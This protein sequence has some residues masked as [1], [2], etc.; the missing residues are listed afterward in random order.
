MASRQHPV[1]EHG[2]GLPE[3]FHLLAH[4]LGADGQDLGQRGDVGAGLGQELVQRRVQQPD[5][6]GQLVH[7]AQDRLEVPLLHGQQ[8]V[9]GLAPSHLV[10][11]Q[12]HLP[13]RVDALFLKEH[14]LGAAQADALG[15]KVAADARLLRQVGV[16]L[17]AEPADR[18]HPAHQ[19]GEAPVGGRAGG[20]AIAVQQHPQHVGRVGDDLSADHFS[21]AA[22]QREPVPLL[23]RHAADAGLAGAVVDGQGVAAHHAHRA[24]LPRHQRRVGGHAAPGRENAFGRLD[25]ADVFRAGLHPAQDDLL[26]PGPPRCRVGGVEHD[27]A[28][29]RPRPRGQ[30]SRQHPAPGLRGFL[31]RLVEDR[32]QHLA[33]VVRLDALQRLFPGDGLGLGHIHGD[34]HRGKAGALAGPGLQQ[35]EPA[36]LDG[37]LEVLHVPV[38]LFQDAGDALELAI[39]VALD[40]G[41]RA[42]G[43]R[44]ADPGH[45]VLAL[46]VHEELAVEPPLARRRIAG[47]GD[48]GAGRLPMLPNTMVWTLTA[49]PQ[50]SGMPYILR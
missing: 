11:G 20:L 5:G 25:A 41:Q 37:E 47:E 33:Q 22:V 39:G 31:G 49:V 3:R 9:Q 44:R 4:R 13:D 15:A 34:A 35:P 10:V 12:D 1:P 18:V 28:G 40:L 50:L 30:S 2:V 48:A 21:G 36:V 7:D 38:V 14:V 26:S 32:A 19:L 24:E 46:G 29:G 45:H 6:H 8:L 42:D 27:P 23:E 17:D 16:G 43:L